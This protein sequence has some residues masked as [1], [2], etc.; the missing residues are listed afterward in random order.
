M[1]LPPYVSPSSEGAWVQLFVQPK[2]AKDSIG[3]VHGRALRVKVKAPPAEGRANRAVEELLARTLGVPR[4]DVEVASGHG[5]RHKRIGVRG[6]A[7]GDVAARLG[8]VLSSPA[9]EPGQEAR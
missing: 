9:H 7:P 5:S 2:A 6:L 3:G 8:G 1:A 4:S